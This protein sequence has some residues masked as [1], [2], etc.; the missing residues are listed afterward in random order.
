VPHLFRNYSPFTVLILIITAFLMKLQALSMPVA[1]VA[2]PDHIVFA[3]ILSFLDHLLQGSATG[4]TW[5]AVIILISQALYINYITVRHKMFS[6]NTYFPA[7][8]YILLTSLN[9]A[10]NYFSEPLLI[11]WL[12][13]IAV[14]IMLT[15]NQTTH[16]RKQLFNAGF[17]ICLPAIFQVPALGFVLLF[18]I[19][20]LLL[21]S[22]NGGEWAVA[23]MG[24]LTPIYFYASTL[25]LFDKLDVMGRVPY[26]GFSFP[27]HIDHPMYFWGMLAGI[28]ILTIIGLITLQQQFGR[29]T[30]YIRRSWYL[31]FTYMIV[32]LGVAVAAFSAINAEWLIVIPALSFIIA[33]AFNLEKSKRFSNF[34]FY[35]SLVLLIFCQLALNK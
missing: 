7:F 3:S 19:A 32:S 2:L 15:F 23:C 17:M 22:F 13:L 28:A 16:P 27:R 10:F 29:V 11:N 18:F 9:P 33:Q 14:N 35:F 30:I 12:V 25:F 6:R 1:P 26:I 5:L 20:L 21:R 24:I 31:V 34:T 8:S 4:Y